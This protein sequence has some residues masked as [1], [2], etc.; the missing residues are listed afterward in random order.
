MNKLDRMQ[1][2]IET[3][4]EMFGVS[5]DRCTEIESTISDML[6]SELDNEGSIKSVI[7][8]ISD[9]FHDKEQVFV[10]YTLGMSIGLLH[11]RKGK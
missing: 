2:V 10:A 8:K 1:S 11:M 9:S 7:Y 5:G 3:S 6:I 4:G